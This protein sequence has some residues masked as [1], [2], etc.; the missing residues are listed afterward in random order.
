MCPSN[1]VTSISP[2]LTVPGIRDALKTTDGP[3]IGV[4]PLIG[5]SAISGP[6][7]KLLI[8]CGLQ[9]SVLGVA[10]SYMDFLDVLVIDAADRRRAGEIEQLNIQTVCTD[11]RM[12][13]A[14]DKARLAQQLL[15]LI[16][17]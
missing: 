13:S 2:I 9:A 5:N 7:H 1:P 15:A 10:N 12:N 4:S 16:K 14:A 8:A 17:K 11:I 3:V 6:A